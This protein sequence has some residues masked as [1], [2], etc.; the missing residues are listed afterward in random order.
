MVWEFRGKPA[1]TSVTEAKR[2]K[3]VQ[4][5]Q[6]YPMPPWEW[7]G[8]E[9]REAGNF[10]DE[11]ANGSLLWWFYHKFTL[12]LLCLC[13]VQKLGLLCYIQKGVAHS[14]HGQGPTP[15][16]WIGWAFRWGH[17]KSEGKQGRELLGLS[18][19]RS[20]ESG[21]QEEFKEDLKKLPHRRKMLLANVNWQG[22][23]LKLKACEEALL[24]WADNLVS[25]YLYPKTEIRTSK[26]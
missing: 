6:R 23:I 26:K 24:C 25:G 4:W 16:S 11:L 8:G 7:G 21:T 14:G 17:W 22:G 12:A 18:G 15:A 1:D 13:R 10:S 2:G 5:E 9:P 20:C 19:S 3:S